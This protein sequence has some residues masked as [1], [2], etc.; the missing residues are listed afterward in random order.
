[1]VGFCSAEQRHFPTNHQ[2]IGTITDAHCEKDIRDAKALGADAF[3][4]N[5]SKLNST[6][7]STEQSNN[8]IIDALASWA[9]DTTALL[10]KWAE[11]VGFKLL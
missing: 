7:V 10:F 2:Q 6:M 1:M 3:A 11:S 9:T 8:M 5:I 4:L